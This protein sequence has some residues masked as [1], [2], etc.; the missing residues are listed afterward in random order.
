M[1]EKDKQNNVLFI[2]THDIGKRYGCY[3]NS[4]IKTPNIDRLASE[5]IQFNNHF[6]QFPLCGPSRANI[7]SGLRPLKTERFTNDPFFPRF[8][9]KMDK[10]FS[11]LPQVFKN[12]GY[13]TYGTGLVFH[14]IDDP[15]SWSKPFWRPKL[16]QDVPEDIKIH[17]AESPN[18]WVN[19]E[20]FE[21]IRTRIKNLEKMGFSMKDILT[22]SGLRKVKGPAVEAGNVDDNAYFDGQTSSSALQYLSNLEQDKPF[23]LAVGYTAGHLP[24]NSPKKYWDLYSK[25]QLKLPENDTAPAGTY[26]WAMGDSEPAQYYTQ[27]GYEEPWTANHEQALELMHGYYAAISYIDTMIGRLINALKDLRLYENTIIVLVSDH[28]FH[29][30]EHGYWGKHNLWDTSLKVPLIIHSPDPS[31]QGLQENHFTEHVDIFPT[32]C[33]MA[34]LPLPDYLEGQSM[35]PLFG[36]AATRGKQAA[37]A[38][39]KHQW[40]DRIKAY[41]IAHSVRTTRY[42]YTIY[43]DTTRHVIAEE[44]FDYEN[45]PGE[46]KN[47]ASQ[48]E[49]LKVIEKLRRTLDNFL[50]ENE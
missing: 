28:G 44:L 33:E 14:D 3:G 32:L 19:N 47:I 36:N 18:P 1:A 42:R 7:F 45:D 8:R 38:H 46:L 22:P 30:G 21:L 5:S 9:K 16:P 40:H 31:M 27:H 43:L 12:N 15:P 11:T 37:F 20:S 48:K 17:N 13:Q 39:R 6:C 35:M 2:I 41:E 50:L 26:P 10:D 23:F 29:T 34:G 4:R 25:D 24:W 49:N